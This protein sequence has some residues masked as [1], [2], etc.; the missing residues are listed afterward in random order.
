MSS[1]IRESRQTAGISPQQPETGADAWLAGYGRG[2]RIA[3]GVVGLA[4]L[5]LIIFYVWAF[6]L[7]DTWEA[8]NGDELR[9]KS[10]AVATLVR[11]GKFEEGANEYDELLALVGDRR[12]KDRDLR[13]AVSEAKRAA[14]R[15][16][17]K[18]DDQWHAAKRR[19]RATKDGAPDQ[20]AGSGGQGG[21][22]PKRPKRNPNAKV[23][24]TQEALQG[25]WRSK[26][27]AGRTHVV[28]IKESRILVGVLTGRMLMGR[29]D[30]YY[31]IEPATKTISFGSAGE[32]RLITQTTMRVTLDFQ[33]TGKKTT[34]VLRLDE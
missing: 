5:G 19:D 26:E 27:T 2:S 7:H 33:K 25:M 4:F 8:D 3:L 15:A 30:V 9:E 1:D 20:P 17:E 14:E 6:V 12:L 21:G 32:G 34:V 28:I 23:V 18:L 22:K 24:L 13:E 10:R 29:H 16:N 31:S 11:N